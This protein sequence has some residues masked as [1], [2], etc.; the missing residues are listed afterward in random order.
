MNGPNLYQFVLSN[1]SSL[2]DPT[3]LQAVAAPEAPPDVDD[4]PDGPEGPVNVFGN[5]N[6]QTVPLTGWK[7]PIGPQPTPYPNPPYPA[8]PGWYWYTGPTVSAPGTPSGPMLLQIPGYKPPTAG[9]A[10]PAAPQPRAEPNPVYGTGTSAGAP[11]LSTSGGGGSGTS[12]PAV[13]TGGASTQPSQVPASA[14]RNWAKGLGY[15][16]DTSNPNGPETWVDPINGEWRLKIK[17]PS[18]RPGIDPGSQ[19][20]RASA[21]TPHG[22][23]IN[24]ITG[25]VGTRSQCGHIPV[26]LDH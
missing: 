4:G 16:L 8:P 14:L 20:P 22:T 2:V 12:P 19:V 9:P 6:W 24:P 10:K 21:R 1:P 11:A 23:Y 7:V 13:A 5:P 3:G 18:N 26:D 17:E 25:Q 15:E